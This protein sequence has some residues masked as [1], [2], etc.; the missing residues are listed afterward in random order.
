MTRSIEMLKIRI[1]QG[2]AFPTSNERLEQVKEIYRL[3]FPGLESHAEKIP[4]MLL[5][6]VKYGFTSVL[7]VAER[8]MGKIDAMALCLHFH[9]YKAS[10][11]DYI[12]V[13]P[14]V[15]SSGLGGALYEAVREYCKRIGTRGLFMEVQPDDPQLTT[16][17][18]LLRESRS[19]LRFYERYG[20]RPILGT[21][22]EM[23][24]GDP[25]TYAYLL[26]DALGQR[27]PLKRAFTK[28]AVRQILTKRFHKSVDAAVVD[29]ILRS[30]KDDPVLIRPPRY[31]K[32][33]DSS[34]PINSRRLDN[35]IA[36]IVSEVHKIH[37][38]PERGYFERP[39][40][41]DALLDVLSPLAYFTSV[42]VREHG[43]K[44]ILSVH[45]AELV[46]YLRT[47]CSKLKV[48]RPV[49]PDTFPIRRPERRPKMLPVQA[50]YYC[51]DSGTPLYH[52]G[53]IAANSAVDTALTGAD[54]ILA[55]R[56]I[57]YAVCRPPGHHAGK[58]YYGGFC[59]FNNAAI[60]A[61]Y[62]SKHAKVAI[63]DIDYHH[64]NGTQDIFYDRQDVLTVSI[65]GH[66]D[67]SYPY[68]SGYE[69][70]KGEGAGKG[71][72]LNLP[73]KPGAGAESYFPVFDKA[74]ERIY[75]FNT[76]VLIVGLGFDI[77]KGDPTGTFQLNSDAMK[78]I[79][80]R[81]GGLN[82]PLLI[83]QE[84]GYNIRNIRNGSLA[85]FSGISRA[86]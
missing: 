81:L 34:A 29:K 83:V 38:P 33:H 24:V 20:V 41:V 11:L 36:L 23:P 16:T 63:L 84:G 19:R 68:F 74:L 28:N 14:G 30:F 79:G 22:Y 77:M 85:F 53:Y 4:D 43:E 55:G 59:Y 47:V 3:S 54:E 76:E 21:E 60:A 65:H 86:L 2:S 56:K 57:A 78:S 15:R 39:I 51:L 1:I 31:I 82:M 18:E 12:A 50:G 49:Y 8:S 62:I 66:P 73:L 7:I 46:Y 26:Y 45:D 13:K 17:K 69:S 10:F 40:R 75:K 61:N 48:G 58:L 64:G 35:P 44:P 71:F 70:E 72:N 5:N 67:H 27:T 6:P 9:E 32:N 42:K 52:N 80:Q 37:H 25:P